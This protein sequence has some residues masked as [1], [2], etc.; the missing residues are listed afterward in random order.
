MGLFLADF[1]RDLW[2]GLLAALKNPQFDPFWQALHFAA[3]MMFPLIGASFGGLWAARFAASSHQSLASELAW[4]GISSLVGGVV[5]VV[6]KEFWWDVAYENASEWDGLKD[7]AHY[8]AG[9]ALSWAGVLISVRA[10]G[11]S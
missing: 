9:M 10:L 11:L 2:R 5:W 1:F 3:G 4:A 7:A 8:W 6:P